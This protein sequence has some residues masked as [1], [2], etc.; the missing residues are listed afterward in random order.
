[1]AEFY[2]SEKIIS[3]NSSTRPMIEPVLAS[4][5]INDTS[6][7]GTTKQM[8]LI[9]IVIFPDFPLYVLGMLDHFMDMMNGRQQRF[10]QYLETVKKDPQKM[11]AVIGKDGAV[12]ALAWEMLVQKEQTTF[13]QEESAREAQIPDSDKLVVR[14]PE[15]QP[16]VVSSKSEDEL[17]KS[18]GY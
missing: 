1:G 18:F 16:F 10:A 14:K 7:F 15:D 8:R 12:D 5:G 3:L 11:A 2:V 6:W 9:E 17:A 13:I 4:W